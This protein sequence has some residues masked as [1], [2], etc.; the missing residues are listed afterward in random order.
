MQ[1]IQQTKLIPCTWNTFRNLTDNQCNLLF[2]KNNFLILKYWNFQS[3]RDIRPSERISM[4]NWEKKNP[5]YYTHYI[6]P[7]ISLPLHLLVYTCPPDRPI[8]W[9]LWI[10]V[11][12]QLAPCQDSPGWSSFGSSC[13]RSVEHM[14]KGITNTWI[15]SNLSS[16]IFFKAF[17]SELF[18]AEVPSHFI[19]EQ[20]RVFCCIK[21]N[22]HHDDI[23]SCTV[24]K[25][26]VKNFVQT[27]TSSMNLPFHFI[28]SW[29]LL[30]STH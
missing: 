10:G 15:H 4:K 24:S 26:S 21:F 8:G 25:S 19:C 14:K 6:K 29:S 18:S 13:T 12:D 7:I 27:L 22:N 3:L 30:S 23:H 16:I 5:K 28:Q 20:I 11:N 1:N 2:S 17:F 9:C